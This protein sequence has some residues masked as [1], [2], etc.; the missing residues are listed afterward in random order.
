MADPGTGVVDADT[1][2]AL[3]THYGHRD[4]GIYATVLEGGPLTIGDEVRS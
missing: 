1:L 3:E 2:G 4:F